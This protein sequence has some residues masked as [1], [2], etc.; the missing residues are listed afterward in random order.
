MLKNS[1]FGLNREFKPQTKTLLGL[2]PFVLMIVGYGIASAVYL[3]NNPNGKLLPSYLQMAEQLW[4]LATQ[5]DKRSG[6]VLLWLD[7]FASLKRLIFSVA[8]AAFTGLFLGVITAFYPFWRN[9]LTPFVTFFSNVPIILLV[10]ILMIAF[11]KDEAFKFVLIYLAT[12]FLITRDLQNSALN[13]PNEMTTKAL[14]LGATQFGTVFR[15][16]LPR[17]IPDLLRTVKFVLGTAWVYT[18][19]AEMISADAGMGYR[20]AFVRR[21]LDMETIIPYVMVVTLL[22]FILNF[23]IDAWVRIVY[24]WYQEDK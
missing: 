4:V 17:L 8:A 24:P 3:T 1:I 10:A 21:F 22:A 11:G 2:L 19:S 16:M 9:L 23:L 12:V 20:I 14:S 5:A 15:I 7:M 6:E 13:I 18:I